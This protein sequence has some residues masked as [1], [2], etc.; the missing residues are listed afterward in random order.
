MGFVLIL[1]VYE[2]RKI[3]VCILLYFAFYFCV[4]IEIKVELIIYVFYR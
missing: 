1:V 4:L 2:N 3:Y